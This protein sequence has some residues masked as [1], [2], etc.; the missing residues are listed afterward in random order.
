MKYC[1]KSECPWNDRNG[2][3]TYFDFEEETV[4]SIS[5]IEEDRVKQKERGGDT[6]DT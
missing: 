4:G 2:I 3:C 6:S 5:C 1:N